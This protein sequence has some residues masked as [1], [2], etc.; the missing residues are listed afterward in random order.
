VYVLDSYLNPLP[1]GAVG[2]LHIGGAGVTRGYLNRPQLTAEKFLDDPFTEV[3]GARLYRTGDLVKRLPDGNIVFV[4]R[5]DGQVKIR[6]L[7]VELGEI[8][9]AMTS[10]PG[11]LQS[12]A[13][14]ISDPAGQK[15]LVGYL[16]LDP[17][18]SSTFS[19]ADLRVALAQQLPTY[20]VP[21]SLLVLER[22]PLT[23]NGKVDKAALPAPEV[24][25]ANGHVAPKTLLET[26]VV[27]M[28]TSLLNVEQVGIEDG[29]FDVGG[30]SLQAMQM[31]TRLRNDL[32]VDVDVPA[33][34]Q[35]PTPKQLAT[36]LRDR[37]GLE[38]VE[39]DE[40]GLAGLIEQEPQPS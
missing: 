36:L 25:S 6:G 39:L 23:G 3:E 35:A 28:Y 17:A 19:V 8:E 22:F 34:F 31:V 5:I 1:V 10:F 15:Q 2:E 4:G 21:P 14:V 20:M 26:L 33:I 38:D 32:A 40:Q 30:N 13:T 12:V 11:V 9:S 16:R 27:D 7:R 37:Y 29:F 24:V 18:A